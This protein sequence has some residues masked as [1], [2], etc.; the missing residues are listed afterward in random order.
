MDTLRVRLM[1]DLTVDGCDSASLGRRQA[2]T[3]LKVL[4][5]H[6][7]QPV[8]VDR[9]ADCLWANEPP[10]RAADQISVLVSRLRGVLGPARIRRSHAGYTLIVDWLDVDALAEYADEAE[11]RLASGAVGAA[12][13]AA[14]AGLALAVGHPPG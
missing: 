1:G 9:L 8:S 7:G 13:A 10:A 12:R 14:S 5:L 11:R 3:L 6:H 2:R 4:A